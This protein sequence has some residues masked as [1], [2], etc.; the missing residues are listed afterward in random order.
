[1]LNQL[2]HPGTPKYHFL[3]KAFL[4]SLTLARS[5]VVGL[6]ITSLWSDGEKVRSIN[7]RKEIPTKGAST[8]KLFNKIYLN[9]WIRPVCILRS[10]NLPICLCRWRTQRLGIQGHGVSELSLP[11]NGVTACALETVMVNSMCQLGWAVVPSFW[12]NT[13]L[14]VAMKVVLDVINIKSVDFEKSRLPS[15]MWLDLSHQLKT[16]RTK[17]EVSWRR[18]LVSR[19]QHR[20]CLSF[21][22]TCLMNVSHKTAIST[23]NLN[24]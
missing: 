16:L 22:P 8:M 7:F 10:C 19:Q 24:Y 17:K 21:Q 15:I 12:S 1:M 3:R 13:C 18:N 14:N 6:Y 9:E 20:N 23:L 11:W 2:S 4:Y 5:P